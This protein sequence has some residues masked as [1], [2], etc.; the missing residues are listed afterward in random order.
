MSSFFGLKPPSSF[1]LNKKKCSGVTKTCSTSM[2]YFMKPALLQLR[3]P[4]P[5]YLIYKMM[6]SIDFA[7][8]KTLILIEL[9]LQITQNNAMIPKTIIF[10]NCENREILL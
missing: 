1:I 9:F 2:Q 10:S 8:K 3:Y 4:P 6:F 5:S 7:T